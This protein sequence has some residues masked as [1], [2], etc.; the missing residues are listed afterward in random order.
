MLKLTNR[1]IFNCKSCNTLIWENTYKY[2]T[3]H[4][5]SCANSG[6][7][8]PNYI[9]GRTKNKKYYCK[10]C[11]ASISIS[12]AK[13]GS[14]CCQICSEK[15][16]VITNSKRYIYKG[17]S[18]RSTWEVKYAKYLDKNNIKWYYEIRKFHLGNTSYTPDFYLEESGF[19]Y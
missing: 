4:C 9:D 13:Y 17:Y 5:N 12:S 2:G 14:G 16:K 10:K 3:G 15:G 18:M 1:K 6:K 7:N 8:N 11:K 19:F